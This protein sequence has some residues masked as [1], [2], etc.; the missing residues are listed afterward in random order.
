MKSSTTN[1][2]IYPVDNGWIL[3]HRGHKGNAD[4]I[5]SLIVFYSKVKDLSIEGGLEIVK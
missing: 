3:K 1:T 2:R 5:H 4:V